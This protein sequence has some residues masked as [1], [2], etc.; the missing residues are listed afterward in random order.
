MNAGQGLKSLAFASFR[1]YG[2]LTRGVPVKRAVPGYFLNGSSYSLTPSLSRAM[3]AASCSLMCFAIVASFMP[4]AGMQR[5]SAQSFLFP[6]LCLRFACLAGHE[7]RALPLQAAHEARHAD[8]GRDADQHVHVVR[9][10]VP[11]HCLGALPLAWLPEDLPQ[12]LAALA[13]D[14]L[15]SMLWARHD[16]APAHPL[17]VR[18]AAGLLCHCALLPPAA[19]DL[20]NHHPGGDGASLHGIVA[21]HP[22]SGRLSMPRGT[23]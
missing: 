8:P 21:I 23:G 16:A 17:G 7:E 9:R 20:N 22:H 14:G 12:V 10:E 11:L 6:D 13:A 4:T 3:S 1:P 15:S 5:P 19:G 18:K 2:R